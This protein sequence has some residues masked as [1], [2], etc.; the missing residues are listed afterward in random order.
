MAGHVSGQ[1]NGPFHTMGGER[2]VVKGQGKKL[3][4]PDNGS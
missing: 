1:R 2:N 3:P 4:I